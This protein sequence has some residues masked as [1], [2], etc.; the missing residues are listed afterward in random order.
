[1]RPACARF[2]LAELLEDTLERFGRDALARIADGKQQRLSVLAE[3]RFDRDDAAGRRE[4]DGVAEQV[5]KDAAQLVVIA[6]ETEAGRR[7]SP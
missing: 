7:Q 6:R 4:L 3:A 1:M 5:D 2:H